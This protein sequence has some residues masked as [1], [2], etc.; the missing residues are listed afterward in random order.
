MNFLHDLA[1]KL[2]DAYDMQELALLNWKESEAD[3]VGLE[4]CARA[5]ID[6]SQYD[7]FYRLSDNFRDQN[8][9]NMPGAGSLEQCIEILEDKKMPN[10]FGDTHPD[11]CW[12]IFDVTYREPSI[13]RKE[14]EQINKDLA[15]DRNKDFGPITDPQDLSLIKEMIR[16]LRI[17]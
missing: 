13:H 12:R 7:E 1:V 14:L 17:K 8:L 9:E 11:P 6:I 10:R 2:I 4:I 5:G 15:N 3:Q 16:Q